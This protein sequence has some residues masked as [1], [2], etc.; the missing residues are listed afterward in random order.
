M[1]KNLTA[2]IPNLTVAVDEECE[3]THAHPNTI[4]LCSD[5]NLKYK[6]GIAF[7]HKRNLIALLSLPKTFVIYTF[8]ALRDIPGLI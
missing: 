5:D 1:F 7:V 8:S 4:T 2:L 3:P 6:A